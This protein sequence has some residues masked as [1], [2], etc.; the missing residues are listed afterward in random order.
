MNDIEAK[1]DEILL[2]ERDAI[3]KSGIWFPNENTRKAEIWLDKLY[4]EILS[5]A[6][7]KLGEFE[8]GCRWWRESGQN[9]REI[10]I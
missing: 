4:F 1:L 8:K 3:I 6:I 10:E 9:L 2:K 5:G 7:D